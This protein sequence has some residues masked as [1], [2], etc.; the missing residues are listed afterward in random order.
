MHLDAML[1]DFATVREGLLHILGGGINRLW[2]EKFP[3]QMG[4][5]LSILLEIHPTEANRQHSMNI[6]LQDEDGRR[7][8]EVNADFQ[9]GRNVESNRRG[10]PIVMPLAISLQQMTI[11]GPGAYSVEILL[12]G[13]HKRTLTVL[14]APPKEKDRRRRGRTGSHE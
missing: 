5:T 11:P 14:A 8:A 1:C 4:V 3:A 2:R 6:V 9:V 7:L 10:E 12:D 13:Q